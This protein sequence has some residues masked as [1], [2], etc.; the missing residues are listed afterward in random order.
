[1][2]LLFL[3]DFRKYIIKL[4][5]VLKYQLCRRLTI[6]SYQKDDVIFNK[7]DPSDKYYIVL[8]G[9]V[10]AINVDS[11]GVGVIVG[12][13]GPGKQLGER[14]VIKNL[15][16]NLKIAAAEKVL[17]LALSGTDFKMILGDYVKQFLEQKV[18]FI[19]TYVP[20]VV[21]YSSA[22]RERSAYAMNMEY[23]KRGDKIIQEGAICEMLYFVYEGE[24]LVCTK[25]R[26]KEQQL[27]KLTTGMC[28]GEECVLLG[29]SAIWTVIAFSEYTAVLTIKRYD[30]MTS[31][32]PESVQSLKESFN[33]KM[34]GRE[35]LK[36]SKS[37][38]LQLDDSSVITK[39]ISDS[40]IRFFPLASNYARKRMYE[41]AIRDTATSRPRNNSREGQRFQK[42][43]ETLRFLSSSRQAHPNR[44]AI[45]PDLKDIRILKGRDDGSRSNRRVSRNRSRVTSSIY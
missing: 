44:S 30:L 4:N 42:E 34:K 13:V 8:R 1:M 40:G 37:N 39:K 9:S 32:P 20:Y 27:S 2:F 19:I 22:H 14:G 41:F 15:P 28:F 11:D 33:L 23:F 38:S 45:T 5:N 25:D 29:R 3:E 31:F 6:E 16:R 26:N 36:H 12:K 21:K 18:Q 10:N 43:I 7:G 24:C 35:F 17:L